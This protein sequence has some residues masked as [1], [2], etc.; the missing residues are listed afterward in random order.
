MF[1]FDREWQ[2]TQNL[3][4]SS[5][6]RREKYE[7][8]LNDDWNFHWDDEDLM[9]EFERDY[10]EC[11]LPDEEVADFH[12]AVGEDSVDENFT[13]RCVLELT[14]QKQ[15]E[16]IS[17]QLLMDEDWAGLAL[18]LSPI[19]PA[20]KVCQVTPITVQKERNPCLLFP[21]I[22]ETDDHWAEL[23]ALLSPLPPAKKV[24]QG[25][26]PTP[27]CNLC[28]CPACAGAGAKPMVSTC[29]VC[30]AQILYSICTKHHPVAEPQQPSM[31]CVCMRVL[32]L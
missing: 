25:T 17:A 11:I 12:L 13:P 21:D 22:P 9:L 1:G 24:C 3:F 7:Y 4:A 10:V 8:D 20:K 5:Q 30:S 28:L 6:F 14:L 32:T 31:C 26:E 2:Q 18:M 23:A 19:P 16:A 15:R 29:A 27:P